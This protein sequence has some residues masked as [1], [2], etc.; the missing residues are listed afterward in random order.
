VQS[1]SRRVL[2]SECLLSA[3]SSEVLFAC[4]F[5]TQIEANP[6]QIGMCTIPLPLL[7]WILQFELDPEYLCH[8]ILISSV[9]SVLCNSKVC[10]A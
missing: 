4:T 2:T 7:P 10:K 8:H 5:S 6:R 9:Q 1:L 3:G